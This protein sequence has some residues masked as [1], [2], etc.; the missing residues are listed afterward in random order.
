MAKHT[1]QKRVAGRRP[2]DREILIFQELD[3]NKNGAERARDRDA[4]AAV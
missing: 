2:A 4:A 3:P 1:R